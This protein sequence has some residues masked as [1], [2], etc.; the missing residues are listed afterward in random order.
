MNL[1]RNNSSNRERGIALL[2]ALFALMLLSAIAAGFMFL[3]N[4]ESS[5]NAN[6]RASQ[7]AYFAA[8]AG[9]QE[10]R[11][12]IMSPANGKPGG[13]LNATVLALTMPTAGAATGGIYITNPA[14]GDPAIQPWN[15]GG[16][17]AVNPFF[18]DTLCK[19]NFA[20]LG[21]NY[22]NQAVRCDPT[23]VGQFPA[24]QW[25]PNPTPSISPGTGTAAAMAF[26]WVR[27]TLKGN[28][29]GSPLS[30]GVYPYQVDK[31]AGVSGLDPRQVCWTGTQQIL[32]P[33]GWV[34]CF[35]PGATSSPYRPVY[36]LTSMAVTPTGS[37]RTLSIE[38]A[39]DPPF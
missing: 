7:Q 16:G 11:A 6:Y 4:T 3:A 1:K 30:G 29:S 37:E 27:I 23:V 34:N 13:D 39:D 9:L 20:G 36:L 33:A 18:D 32:S 17:G 5:V 10:A 38:V 28:A 8:R 24:G 25:V 31:S 35:A 12:R 14:A 22:G 15:P 26:K 21:L 19:A 2:M